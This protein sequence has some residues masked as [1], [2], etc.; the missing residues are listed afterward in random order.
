MLS[1][2]SAAGAEL[3]VEIRQMASMGRRKW[4][5]MGLTLLSGDD[6]R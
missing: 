6:R 2:G 3:A 4:W 1:G 5:S